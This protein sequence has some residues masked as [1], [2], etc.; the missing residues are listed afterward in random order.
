MA[1]SFTLSNVT[2]NE[3]TLFFFY[4]IIDLVCDFSMYHIL[5]GEKLLHASFFVAAL[6]PAVK[7]SLSFN[8]RKSAALP[9]DFKTKQT[10]VTSISAICKFS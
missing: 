10:F 7:A 3:S 6:M 2:E 5:N 9:H 8:L 1:R 4:K